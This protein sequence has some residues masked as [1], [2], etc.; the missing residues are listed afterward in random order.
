MAKPMKLAAALAVAAMG[1]TACGSGGGGGGGAGSG[2]NSGGGGKE[3][4]ISTDL[5]KQGAAKD[6]T[7][8]TN[9]AI[10]LYLKQLNNKAGDYTVKLKEYD[11]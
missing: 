8:S 3:L 6:A 1:V 4:V 9:N 2:G 10:K 11:D 5:P 7:D